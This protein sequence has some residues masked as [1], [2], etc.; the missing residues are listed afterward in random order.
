MKLAI[1]IPTYRR[2][3]GTT[4][5]FL[6]RALNSVLLQTHQDFKVYLIGDHYSN[7]SEFV[8]L[9]Q[10]IPPE[11]MFALNLP[12][13]VERS[14]YQM[15]TRQLWCSGGVNAYNTAIDTCL[16]DGLDF[17]CHLDHDDFWAPDHLEKINRVAETFQDAACVYTCAFYRST[18]QH[19]PNT[20]LDGRIIEHFPVP[21]QTVHASVC[22]NH[23]KVNLKY[24]DV[25]AETGKVLEAD[26]DM[27][28]R[29]KPYCTSLELKS[30]LISTITCYHLTENQ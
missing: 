5:Q 2:A 10:M 26:I 8:E 21:T 1:G 15:G 7:E 20:P 11:K 29:L 12:H 16:A 30:Y 17:M 13:A 4:S 3:D 23:R 9:S 6:R 14:K 25:F 22:I 19:L 27:W 18:K 24:R 28:N